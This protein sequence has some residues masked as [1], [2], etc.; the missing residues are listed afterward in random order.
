MG[1]VEDHVG[2][3]FGGGDLGGKGGDI[4]LRRHET[5][6]GVVAG[7]GMAG[8]GKPF[9]RPAGRVEAAPVGEQSL[10]PTAGEGK[11]EGRMRGPNEESGEGEPEREG[12]ARSG[13]EVDETRES[14]ATNGCRPKAKAKTEPQGKRKE[15]GTAGAGDEGL[16][17]AGQDDGW[18]TEP[19]PYVH[20]TEP[21]A[22]LAGRLE[23]L[24]KRES[25]L[26]QKAQDSDDDKVQC[27]R[28]KLEETE[29]R[30]KAAGGETQSKLVFSVM[31]ARKEVGEAEKVLRKAEEVLAEASEQAA[32]WLQ[33]EERAEA[34]VRARTAELANCKSRVAHLGFQFA[35]EAGCNVEGYVVACANIGPRGLPDCGASE[36]IS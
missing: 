18:A 1:S 9:A 13:M 24:R 23:A 16:G 14:R 30:V 3:R 35:A 5:I 32:K 11:G 6:G 36:D 4:G 21:R 10:A 29:R 28:R 33:A 8:K 19:E 34:L 27:A 17:E 2:G 7:K 22:V 20:P 25:V 15:R 26:R 31:D 12:R